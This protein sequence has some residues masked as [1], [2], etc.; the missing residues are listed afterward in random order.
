[1]EFFFFFFF[2]SRRRHTRSLCDWSSDVCSSDLVMMRSI[3]A[4]MS[5]GFSRLGADLM[6]V[7]QDA[8]TNITVALLTVEPTD[9]TVDA[10]LI[11]RASLAGIARSAAQ[12]VLR[13][14]RSGLGAAGES[15]DLIGFEP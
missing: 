14:D 3:E 5:V 11:Q 8:L 6:V 1:M 15:V 4:S 7:A 2:S 12:R 10:D 13:T 9:R